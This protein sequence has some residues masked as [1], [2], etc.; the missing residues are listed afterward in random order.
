MKKAPKSALRSFL[1]GHAGVDL[2]SYEEVRGFIF[3]V[4]GTPELVP[5]SEWL[6]EAF[7]GQLPKFENEEQAQAVLEEVMGIYNLAVSEGRR[8]KRLAPAFGKKALSDLEEDSAARF[9][10]RGFLRGYSW[11]GELWQESMAD[12]ELEKELAAILLVLTFFAS[13]KRAEACRE[14][15]A[16]DKSLE[17]VAEI[18]QWTFKK[19]MVQYLRLGRSIYEERLRYGQISSNDRAKIG[20]NEPCA[21]GSGK[22]YKKCC[23]ARLN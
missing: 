14:E 15:T 17:E 16:S 12:E 20:R 3:A 5:P 4:A 10:S 6:P 2:V 22:K 19:A 9:W 11:L 23:G 8:S 21:C 7:N 1:S 18:M 13:R